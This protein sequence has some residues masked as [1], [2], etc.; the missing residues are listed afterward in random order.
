MEGISSVWAMNSKAYA[1]SRRA[2]SCE[3]SKH[4]VE[5]DHVPWAQLSWEFTPIVADANASNKSR[6]RRTLAPLCI[7]PFSTKRS[8]DTREGIYVYL[9]ASRPNLLSNSLRR[10]APCRAG[11]MSPCWAQWAGKVARR[12]IW[13]AGQPCAGC[14]HP[15][16]GKQSYA[17]SALNGCALQPGRTALG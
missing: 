14:R 2:R 7:L 13:K 12:A 5:G 8:G 1:V 9:P 10:P 4:H 3:S 11:W 15:R 17:V 16:I 6:V